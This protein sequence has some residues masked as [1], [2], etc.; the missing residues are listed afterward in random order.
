M[1]KDAILNTLA[2]SANIAQFVSF[3]PD[4]MQRYCRIS[5]FEANS[6]FASPRDAIGAL[7]A[8][9][10]DATV[11]VRC[12]R[13]NQTQGNEFI[14]GLNDV[15]VVEQ[16]IRRLTGAGFYVIVNE[17]VD[18]R[19]GGVSGVLQNGCI[20]FAPGAVPR[21][22]E[23]HADDPI[24]ALPRMIA[25][26]MLETV[27]GFI[28]DLGGYDDSYRV[29]FSIHPGARGWKH[30]HTIIWEEERLDAAPIQPF[31]SWPNSFSR[32][33]GDKAY[34]LLIGHLL[35]MP[36]PRCTVFPRNSTLSPFTFGT[37]TGAR[38]RWTRTCPSRQEPGRFSTVRQW[39]DPYVLM[40]GEDPT[41]EHL[42]SCIV[43]DEVSARYAGAVITNAED[44]PVVEGLEGYGD[45]FMLGTAKP[46][47]LPDSIVDDVLRLYGALRNTMKDSLRFEWVHDGHQVWLLQ[48]HKG[49]T[50]S[51]GR[52]IFPGEPAHWIDFTVSRGLEQ[53]HTVVR[54][55]TES[56]AGV[57][58]VGNVGMT[59]HIADVLRNARIPSLIVQSAV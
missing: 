30:A 13:E 18:V 53:L 50:G 52:V 48:L 16:H 44:K 2:E 15:N 28:P 46:G 45:E 11:N 21:F 1:L 10:P 14:Y 19:D 26:R 57:R 24:P 7:L 9:A 17:T 58:V 36:V 8:Q 5:G 32:L 25:E 3:A 6:R 33:L 40:D 37:P 59:S 31:Y 47:L 12:F 22:V 49:Q 23:Q 56:G 39:T 55:A 34:G 51:L 41:K 20:E 29:E 4:G 38:N 54:S 42:A 35:G 27:Y 43:Q